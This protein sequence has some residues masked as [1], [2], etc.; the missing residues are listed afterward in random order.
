MFT[1]QGY[2]VYHRYSLKLL[3]TKTCFTILLRQIIN[4]PQNTILV[5][6]HTI[7]IIYPIESC[8]LLACQRTR[9][10]FHRERRGLPASQK[11]GSRCFCWRIARL[12]GCYSPEGCA[13]SSRS[14]PARTPRRDTAVADPV[15]SSAAVSSPWFFQWLLLEVKLRKREEGGSLKSRRLCSQTLIAHLNMGRKVWLEIFA[16]PFLAIIFSRWLP[17]IY[18]TPPPHFRIC[19]LPPLYKGVAVSF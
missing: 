4:T 14:K 8:I 16:L 7:K 13:D 10:A 6:R 9:T 1:E 18:R 3:F 15:P 2:R 17:T 19:L 12:G 11:S 5:V